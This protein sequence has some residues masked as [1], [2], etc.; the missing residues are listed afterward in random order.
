M[1]Y[2]TIIF[3]LDGTLLDTLQDLANSTNFA[4]ET[5]GFPTRTMEEVRAFV[6]NG[7]AK[8]IERAVP[9]GTD[10]DMFLK[11]LSV[12]KEHYALHCED[13]TKLYDGI[14][15]LLDT[16]LINGAKLA[17][18]SNKVDSAVRVL[19]EKYL[20]DRIMVSVGDREGIAKKPSPDSVFEVLKILNANI[21]DAAYIGDS[22]VDILTARNA[23][24]DAIIVTWGF[25]DKAFLVQNGASVL[26]DSAEEL[27]QI[28]LC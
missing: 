6:G 17:V 12:F 7:V 1:R 23:K 20:G 28:L 3:D 2:H 22:E 19:C 13:Q 15:P 26:A 8:L 9:D 21:E 25:R 16:L 11:T 14:L 27:E 5:M 24:M 10:H 4:L 18:V